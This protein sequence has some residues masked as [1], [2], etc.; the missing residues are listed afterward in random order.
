MPPR[1]P[2]TAGKQLTH[3]ELMEAYS[4]ALLA[5]LQWASMTEEEEEQKRR[6]GLAVAL[7][8]RFEHIADAVCK[9]TAKKKERKS[10]NGKT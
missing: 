6:M 5:A 1:K 8:R 9:Q 10:G 4:V 2:K 7:G 3:V